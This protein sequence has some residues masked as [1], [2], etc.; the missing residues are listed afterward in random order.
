MTTFQT[1]AE[2]REI[3]R[4]RAQQLAQAMLPAIE[5]MMTE[6]RTAAEIIA[7]ERGVSAPNYAHAT[8]IVA[9]YGDGAY[10]V[11]VEGNRYLDCIT[12]YST[13]PFGFVGGEDGAAMEVAAAIAAQMIT[14]SITSRAYFTE[15]LP[16]FLGAICD[17]TGFGAAGRVL[18]SS[19]GAEAVE[20]AIQMTFAW[21][22]QH[23]GIEDPVIIVA[24]GNFHGR[25]SRIK[26]LAGQ[27]DYD[28]YKRIGYVHDDMRAHVLHVPYGDAEALHELLEQEYIGADGKPHKNRDRVA[29]FLVEPIQGERGIYVP[30]PGY[31][32]QL[33][34]LAAQE[35]IMV[36]FDEIQTGLGRTGKML[37]IHHELPSREERPDLWKHIAV[38]LGKGLGGGF[39][40]SSAVIADEE[41]MQ[42]M[43]S[44]SHG[45]T[46]GGNP[47]AAAAGVKTLELL[48]ENGYVENAARL[49]HKLK[50][51][52]ELMGERY[53]G[54]FKDVRGKGLLIGV[55]I[56]PAFAAADEL[57]DA[58]L[59]N[60]LL[61]KVTHGK[62]LRI[63]PPLNITEKEVGEI[64]ARFELA[65]MDVARDKGVEFPP[66][67][68]RL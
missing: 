23:K 6:G 61:S 28:D 64:L 2:A 40:P 43:E 13:R 16:P 59:K 35:D 46:N 54:V 21:A 67:I 53:P 30:D 47:L 33:A 29:G 31:L 20:T 9:A 38:I 63:A 48:A 27:E 25:T 42:V 55:E 5:A 56:D 52:L 51:G 37:A 4:Q 39:V 36:I 15:T 66:Q 10:V 22:K 3:A 50:L 17:V 60:G 49:G 26:T 68:A 7:E 11:D 58:L 32:Y 45:S 8:P 34:E 14:L 57:N 24:D 65:V 1:G 19:G 44:G 12:G 62:T 41:V 18:P